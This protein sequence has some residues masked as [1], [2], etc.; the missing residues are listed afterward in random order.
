MR[1]LMISDFYPPFV[2]GVEVL[3]STLSR[4]LA[5]RGHDVVVATLAA[6]DLPAMELD[7]GVR[8]HRIRSTAQ[9]SRHLFANESR[10][11]APPAPD[12]EAVAG[13]RSVVARERPEIVH[14]HDWLA[15]SYLPLKRRR[16]PALVMSLHYF[17]L[18]CPKKSLLYGGSPCSGP[19]LA[20]CLGCA[21]RHYGRGKGAAVVLAQRTFSRAERALVDLFLPVSEDTA[22]G[23]GLPGS[24]LP[25]V[26]M[27]NLVPP[28]GET[29]A[30]EDLLVQLPDEPFLL[31]VGD[32]RPAKGV[33]VLLDAYSRLATRP[34]LVLIGKV[35]ADSPRDFPPGVI[36][37]R[38]WPNAAVRA[39]MRRSLALVTPSLWREPFGIVVAEA[40]AAGRPVVASAIGGIPEI[41]RDAVEGLLVPPGDTGLLAAALERI[42]SDDGLT[43]ALAAKARRRSQEYVPDTVVPRIE[44]A[45]ERATSAHACRRP[46]RSAKRA[47]SCS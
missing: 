44:A 21:G 23:N 17:T 32:V 30:H 36:L 13:L 22:S 4:E 9:R 26:V 14:G 1:I 24:G 41:V 8:V 15:R 31:F 2:G 46:R 27:P 35:W 42:V 37:L 28:A 47:S 18:S 19:A 34:P 3:V 45:Y 11:W 40:L 12:P 6:D 7:D 25:Y 20:K 39:A 38:N 5:D 43:E 29:A 10:P 16:G 33:H